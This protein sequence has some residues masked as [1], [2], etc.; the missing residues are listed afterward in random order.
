LVLATALSVALVFAALAVFA[1]EAQA[2]EAS[3]GHLPPKATLMKD[4]HV[5]QVRGFSGGSWVYYQDGGR[6]G[7]VYDNFGEYS[8]PKADEVAAGTRL[9]VRLAKPERP[10]VIDTNAY[11]RVKTGQFGGK[12]PAG[13]K[14]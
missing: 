13:Q 7:T 14:W 8:F 3:S 11:P 5:L 12:L 1:S 4:S 2:S 10:S 6:T 9:H